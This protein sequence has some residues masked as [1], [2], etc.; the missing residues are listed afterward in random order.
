MSWNWRAIKAIV[1]KDLKQ[2]LEN[3]MVWLP[4][5]VVPAM[6]Q[7]IMPLVMTLLPSIVGPAEFG[8]GDLGDLLA[9]L[10]ANLLATL[11]GLA[12]GEQW[13]ILSGNYIFAPM[14]LIVPLMVSSILAADSFVGERERKTLEGLLYTPVSD[15][16]LFVAKVLTALLPALVISWVSF[17]VYGLVVNLA[18]YS[19]VGYVF[20]PWPIWWPLVL[21]VAPAIS[22]VGLGITVLISSKAKTFM[23]AQ[24]LSGI[25]VL[26]IVFLM[27]AQV[28]GLFFLNVTILLLMG[29]FIWLIGIWLVWVGAKTFSRG[30]LIARI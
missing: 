11:G 8:S 12:G 26:P 7:V 3:R 19:A 22:V 6:L 25:L 1:R 23:Q 24:Q 27:I 30:E 21:W 15:T 4:M 10:P 16:E 17:V 9:V 20:F 18:G 28:S 5:V 13:I 2:V 14:F 29:L